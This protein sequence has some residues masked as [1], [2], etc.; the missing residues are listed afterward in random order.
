MLAVLLAV[1][2]SPLAVLAA[3]AQANTG[4]TGLVINEVYGGGGNSGAQYTNDFIELF[5]PTSSAVVMSNWS[6]QYASGSG[7]TW[8]VTSISGTVPA[9][10]YF[11]VQEAAGSTASGALPTP[12][13]TGTLALSGT[14]GKVLLR[15]NNTAMTGVTAGNVNSQSLSG[16]VDFVGFGSTATSYEGT[17]PT[18]APSN[19]TS[20]TRNATHGDTDSNSADFTAVAPTPK[21]SST[22]EGGGS[23]PLALA[24]ISNVKTF[25]NKAVALQTQASGGTGTKTYALTGDPNTGGLSIDQTGLISGT[26]TDGG[27]YSLT[28]TVTAGSETASRTFQLNAVAPSHAD[29]VLVSEVWGDGGYTDAPFAN[30]YIE[31][32]NPTANP[33]NV[34]G[35]SIGYAPYNRGNNTAVPTYP[36][37][38]TGSET[39]PAGG[40][41][42]IL[43]QSD[44]N[45]G[46]AALPD[47]DATVDIDYNTFDYRDGFIA[48]LDNT[49]APTLPSGDI[50]A[51][52]A[53]NAHIIDAVGYGTA[54]T[55]EGTKQPTNLSSET[56]VSRLPVD[57]DSN[58]S[59]LDWTLGDL[60]PTNSDGVVGNT[61]KVVLPTTCNSGLPANPTIAQV[62]GTDAVFSPYINCTVTTTGVVT[63]IYSKGFS[64]AGAA[65]CGYCGFYIQ[66]PGTVDTPG[67][68]DA[69]FVSAGSTFTNP[70]VAIGDAVSVTGK[71]AEFGSGETLTQINATS[72][73]ISVTAPQAGGVVMQG[74]APATY[75]AREAHEGEI[76][77]PTD[78][79]VTDTYNFESQGELGLAAG[80]PTGPVATA[81]EGVSEAPLQQPGQICRDG[82]SP[83]IQAA[84]ADVKN[85][86]YFLT[87]GTTYL[88][89]SN[90]YTPNKAKNSDI[91]YPFI[92]KTHSARVGAQVTFPQGA[93]L[94]S[95]NKKW[96][97]NPPRSVVATG[98]TA[99]AP[100]SGCQVDLGSDVVTFED[101]RADNAAP[102]PAPAGS[103]IRFA[104]YNV[105]NFFSVPAKD[106]ADANPWYSCTYNSDRDGN[107]IQ[108]KDCTNPT[109]MPTAW[110]PVTGAVTAYGSALANA[111]RGAGRQE[112][113][114]RQTQ[115]IVTAINLLGADVVALEEIG[116]PNK[117]KLGVKNSPLNP[118]V[119]NTKDQ[120]Q[121][122]ALQWRDAT[123]SYLVDHLN[124]GLPAGEQW[125]FAASPEETTDAT[126]VPGLC[127]K[128]QPNG[129]PVPGPANL[130]G[131]CSYSSGMDVIRSAFIYKKATV[132]PVGQADLDLPGYTVNGVSDAWGNHVFAPDASPFD[133]A[134][135]PFAQ[136]FKPVGAKNDE[137]FALI[138]NHFKS[139]GDAAAP[140]G[141][142][143]GGDKNDP[144]HGA[145]N[146]SR[147]AQAKEVMRFANAFAAKWHTDKVF[148]LGDFN[149]YSGED[150]IHAITDANDTEDPLDFKEIH[151]DDPNDTSYVFTTK[152]NGIGYGGAGSLDHIL[153]SAGAR[154]TNPRTDIWEINANESD[155]YDYGR[156]NTNATDFFD[157]TVPWRGSDHNPE[158]IDLTLPSAGAGKKV[159]DVQI[160]GIND[161]HGRL[162]A[163]SADGGAAPLAGAVSSL[164]GIYGADE[165]VLASAG[166]NVGASIFESF[167][168][169]DKPTLDALNAMNLQVS[170]VGNHEFDRGVGD[171]LNRIEQPKSETNPYGADHALTWGD[172]LAA[173]VVWKDSTDGHTAGQPIS[174]PT[175]M[176]EVPNSLSGTPIKIGFVG[177]VTSDLP[178]LQSPANLEGVTVLDNADTV[179]AVNHYAADL[180]AQG[181]NLV[182]LL[183]HE[184]AATTACSTMK[185]A[186]T[187][188]S[189]ILNGVDDD[190]DAILSGHTHLEYSC[191]FAKGATDSNPLTTRPVMQ[192]ASYG[193]ALD[194]L[195]YSFDAD[196]KPVDLIAN[197]VGVK[198]PGG[199]LFSYGP[200]A[201]VQP[202]VDQA[203]ADSAVAGAK[204]LGKMTAPMYRSK[205]SD[206]TDNRGGESV[207]GNQVAEIQRWATRG[208]QQ[209]GAQI[210]F[211]NPGGLRADALGTPNGDVYDLTYREAA[212]VQPFANELVNMKLTGAQIKKVL[213]QQW[214]RD[215]SGNIP[216]RPFL[217]LGISKGFTYTYSEKQD[218]AKPTGAM[219]GTVT[220]MWLN[221]EPIDLDATYSV[222]VNSFLA[223]GGDN[224]WELNNGKDKL[225]TEQTDLQGQVDYMK[226][227]A[228]EPLQVDSSQRGVRV[229]FP[230]DA[231]TSYAPG[232]T[233]A[234][235]LASLD[236]NSPGAVKDDTVKVLV[237]DQVVA[238]DVPV[239][240]GNG[241]NPDDHWGTASVSFVL[242]TGIPGGQLH[243]VGDTTGTDVPLPVA[244]DEGRTAT[245]VSAEDVT[246]SYGQPA[247]LEISVSPSAATGTVTVKEGTTLLDTVDVSDGAATF[248]SSSLP[249]GVHTLTLRYSGSASHAPS[250]STVTVT[251]TK[252]ESTVTADA[253]PVSVAPGGTS[254]V[255]AHVA[256]IGVTPSGSVTCSAPGLDD[257]TGTLDASG[258]ATCVVGPWGTAGD[259]TVTVSYGGDQVTAPGSTTTTVTVTKATPTMSA[260]ASPTSLVRDTDT[261]TIT[262]TL[263]TAADQLGGT[264]TCDDGSPADVP[265]TDGT[266]TCTVGPFS[267]VGDKT[268]TLTYSGD[269]DN[270]ATSTSVALH[271]T[272]P[273]GGG[274]TPT[275][276]DTTVTGSADPI[277]WGNG[278]TVYVTVKS[279]KDTTGNVVLREGSTTIGTASVA[280]DGT[281]A[282]LVP[283]KALSVGSHTLTIAYAGDAANKAS[284]GTVTVTVTKAS[285]TTTVASASPGTVKVK[286]G[287]TDVA[288]TV[289]ADGV[290]PT[291]TVQAL[292]DG[293]VVATATL[294]GGSATLHV[295]PFDRVGQQTVT[296]RY[297]GD[298]NVSGSQGTTSVNVVKQGSKLTVS[299]SP[300]RAKAGK[301]RVTLQIGLVVDGTPV[302][303]TVRVELPGGD[304]LKVQ[305]ENGQAS[306][307]LP[308]FDKPGKKT[309]V[310]TYNGSDTVEKDRATD[311]IEVVKR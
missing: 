183:T 154:A 264:V 229:T 80:A 28:A 3:P 230:A 207:L 231:P 84:Q 126:S 124:Q 180:K 63:A 64:T 107:P 149:A 33:V 263:T 8:A 9:G 203:V 198:G 222:T 25:T 273:G 186:G 12:D 35:W 177:T 98:C 289:S 274:G 137:G 20:A 270:S 45:G 234:F 120:G 174:D 210:A 47:A 283:A 94:D 204:V 215:A 59:N 82:D 256:A 281:A 112:D 161:F 56:S 228:T 301:T 116:N 308:K 168:Q 293:Q 153:A 150:P 194:Q 155:V 299:H 62:Q 135:E 166:D 27:V 157:G 214:Q 176:I 213:E 261:S 6:V 236:L 22:V 158:V 73:N 242:P 185:T 267:T 16:L 275:P 196:N 240:H 188:F 69:V 78:V 145:F 227:Y 11:L 140:A 97:L 191:S 201:E 220:G 260:T 178:S 40:Y 205:L 138:V 10:G 303:G 37:T 75:A 99:A 173:N 118:D 216:A 72:A 65:T 221:G 58:D 209:G 102:R 243:V 247:T 232:A 291:G 4:G 93:I 294:S 245:T 128:V 237:G 160:L 181:A 276:V 61:G 123:V 39:I 1:V 42:L 38:I 151:S 224:F 125:A 141:P 113:L 117:L 23:S 187:A 115:K 190:V 172:Y 92:D 175:K 114:D 5:N 148:M 212:D 13:A 29:H 287:T 86:G 7:T 146:A 217:K 206:G 298:A 302:N 292:V 26:P 68:S 74:S 96:Y 253:T 87:G 199:A 197:N 244:A 238:S 159:T 143:K 218:P 30:D 67:A 286:K 254:T 111:P 32:Y 295:G 133:N 262:V 165:T 121:G 278:G 304:V 100:H 57:N 105:E 249:V 81:L 280:A 311:V 130:A 200:D 41:Y 89:S 152:V 167:T 132:V 195:V 129:T 258:D 144:L 77:Q 208:A 14:A 101:T 60:T 127:A 226:Q 51:A 265:V 156:F 164:R 272:A 259:R 169:E 300:S 257:S 219:L 223:T 252:V 119:S 184:G 54:N 44:A 18:P 241:T 2:V 192:G 306:V 109:G 277:T 235:D 95:R 193:T 34:S 134:R 142:A 179:A 43:G 251:V 83:C 131:T 110:D 266:A 147:V 296:I 79:V 139:K 282:V 49:T 211:M 52:A 162:I 76:F 239:A 50:N 271:V 225:D 36:L 71:V 255:T 246:V 122:T 66:T 202:I 288:V 21:N 248:T 17:G 88:G 171:L 46:G 309:V 182:V 250:S 24:A 103:N 70:T 90:I 310:L 108:A 285:S 268:V 19:S 55:F 48:L 170:S 136:Y 106:F 104:T 290:V 269:A 85:R 305:V 279:T 284:T 233:V 15:S 307:K 189:T 91:P 297:S 31:L 53:G 163:D